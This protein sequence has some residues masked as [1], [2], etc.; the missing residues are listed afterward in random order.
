MHRGPVRD[1]VTKTDGQINPD[2]D[3]G[4]NADDRHPSDEFY[5]D[6]ALRQEIA[7]LMDDEPDG[8]QLDDS[9]R[10]ARVEALRDKI[11]DGD[12]MSE[13]MIGEIV[14]RLLRKWKL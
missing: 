4:S 2:D 6:A 3:A 11:R 10:R 14:D 9:E 5:D 12:Y 7:R 1:S 13:A 8:R